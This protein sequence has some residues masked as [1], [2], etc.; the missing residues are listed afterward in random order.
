MNIPFLD[1]KS[2]HSQIKNEIIDEFENFYDSNYFVLG[3]RVKNFELNFANYTGTNYCSGVSNGLDAIFLCLKSIGITKGDQ[4]IVPSNTYIATILAISFTGATPILVEPDF[5]TYNIDVNKVE[6]KINKHTKC[7]IPVHLYGLPSNMP[8]IIQI[9]NKYN[10]YV[11]EDNAQ[12]QGA[13]IKG[14]LTGS[15]GTIN[16]TSFYPGKNLG[17]LGDAGAVTTDS[18]DLY[19]KIELY[20]NYGSNKKYFNEIIGYNMRLDELQA[21][22][23]NIKLKMI[24]IWNNERINIAEKYSLLLKNVGDL[25]LPQTPLDFKHVFHLFVIRTNYRNDLQVFLN[26]KGIG[27]LIHYPV[28]PHKQKAYSNTDISKNSYKISE[29]ISDTCLS[30]P[31]YPG[32]SNNQIE[33]ICQSVKLFYSTITFSK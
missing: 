18:F 33:Y 17:A 16:A 11:I 23:L 31:I 2:M 21:G 27:T 26:N 13:S 28:P 7:I 10:L 9:A 15:W 22:V 8:Q 14:K 24:D 1:F 3:S 6:E 29:T 20:R 32:L 4:V 19:K 30:L 25:I 5:L 12:S